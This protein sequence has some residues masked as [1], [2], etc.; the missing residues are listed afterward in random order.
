M[1]TYSHKILY[2]HVVLYYQPSICSLDNI[3]LVFFVVKVIEAKETCKIIV[4][5][6]WGYST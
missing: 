3:S 2:R 4:N 1:I 5:D 6:K